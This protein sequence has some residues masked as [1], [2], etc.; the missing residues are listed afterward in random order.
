MMD[1]KT[2]KAWLRVIK[3]AKE[4]AAEEARTLTYL[5]PEDGW[6]CFFCGERFNTV[7]AARDHFG[8]DPTAETA[9][10]IKAGEERG[11]VMALRKAQNELRRY[12]AEDSV[13]DRELHRLRADHA[14]AIIEAEQEAYDKGLAD[15][16]D[17]GIK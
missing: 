16:R 11:L 7:G 2:T 15:G 3:R 5:M 1:D 6:R 10:Q 14:Q 4:R 12:E 13:T 8:A 9:C 17:D